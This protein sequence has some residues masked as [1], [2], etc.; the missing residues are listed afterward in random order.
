MDWIKHPTSPYI[1]CG[2]WRITKQL[3]VTRHYTLWDLELNA[4]AI[5]VGKPIEAVGYFGTVEEAKDKAK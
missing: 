1:G 2:K 3:N 5:K 4:K